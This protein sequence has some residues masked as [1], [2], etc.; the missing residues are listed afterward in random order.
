MQRDQVLRIRDEYFADDVEV[1]DTMCTWSEEKLR[2]FFS[3]GGVMPCADDS[4]SATTVAEPPAAEEEGQSA[5]EANAP[6]ALEAESPIDVSESTESSVEVSLRALSIK[7]LKKRC[8]ASGLST[9]GCLNKDDLVRCALQAETSCSAPAAAASH[10]PSGAD[11]DWWVHLSTKELRKALEHSG[12]STS[13]CFER[14]DFESLAKLHPC[15]APKS[16]SPP[17]PDGVG[18]PGSTGGTGDFWLAYSAKDLR[19]L[20]ND[21]GISTSGLL[22]KDDFLAAA[23]QHRS[24]L[25]SAV[26]VAPSTVTESRGPAGSSKAMS[27]LDQRLAREK[28]EKQKKIKEGLEALGGVVHGGYQIDVCCRF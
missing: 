13:A 28:A 19:N 21:R 16:G 6:S 27:A 10:V 3:N 24:T 23:Q 22:D 17:T 5:A 7:E 4:A 25:L 11:R 2:A 14:S 1:D 12:Y 20:L 18:S 9:D 26:P 8:T 15:A